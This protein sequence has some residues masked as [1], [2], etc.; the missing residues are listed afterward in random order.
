MDYLPLIPPMFG[1]LYA[2]IRIGNALEKNCKQE[3]R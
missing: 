2:L 1:I 3:G